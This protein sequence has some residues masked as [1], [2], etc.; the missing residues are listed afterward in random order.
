MIICQTIGLGK[1]FGSSWVLSDVTLEIQDG[2]RCA[3][4]GANGT[5]KTTLL[6]LMAGLDTADKGEIHFKKGTKVGYLAQLPEI[7]GDETVAEVLQRPFA[8]VLELERRMNQ[9]AQEMGNVDPADSQQLN[10]LLRRFD[11]AQSAF[12][13]ADGYEIASKISRVANGLNIDEE[14]QARR[15]ADLSGGEQTKVGLAQTLL[16]EPDLL[17]LDEPTNHLDLFAVEWLESFLRAYAGAVLIVSHDR[18]FLDEVVNQVFELDNGEV[19]VYHG[20][21]SAF[22]EERDRAMLAEFA[23]YEEQQKKIQKMKEAIKRMREWANQ[24]NPPNAGMHR[25]ASS[26]EKA[27]LRMEKRERPNIDPRQMK[28]SFNVGGRSGQDVVRLTGAAKSFE[29]GPLFETV[30]LHV[31]FGEKV[32]V[33]GPNGIGKS[34]LLKLILGELQPDAGEVWVGP[35]V[36]IGYLSQH[37]WQSDDVLGQTVIDCFRHAVPVAVG[38]AR[39]ILARFLFFGQAVFCRVRDLSG[40]ERM[41]LRLAQMMYQSHNLLVLDEPTNHLDIPSREVLEEAVSEFPGTVIAVS[42]DRYFLNKLFAPT[43]WLADGRLQRYEGSY[44]EAK[45]RRNQ[46]NERGS[47][48]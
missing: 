32:A 8:E 18:Y 42:H 19:T 2:K 11:E 23:A 43:Y 1:T 29:Q 6:S 36:R 34:T 39:H 35:S 4:V 46:L 9:Y 14:M 21:Y 13:E 5:G 27:L 26:M 44:D 17:L 40:G 41:R 47:S 25:R 33:V 10:R 30:D 7:L 45:R 31:R 22:V 15:F 12:E 38:D 3:L 20:N 16:L 37:I 24:A 28:L 48:G